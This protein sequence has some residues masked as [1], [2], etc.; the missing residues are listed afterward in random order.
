MH[1]MQEKFLRFTEAENR[2]ARCNGK[3]VKKR[4][5]VFEVS[6]VNENVRELRESNAAVV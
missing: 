2:C 6:G 4:P 1:K 5:Q 3:L